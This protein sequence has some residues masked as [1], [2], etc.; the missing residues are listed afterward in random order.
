MS[1]VVLMHGFVDS[2]MEG[3][4]VLVVSEA[5]EAAEDAGVAR[6]LVDSGG[7]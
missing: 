4:I 3:Q 1:R 6:L 7:D 2:A 5:G